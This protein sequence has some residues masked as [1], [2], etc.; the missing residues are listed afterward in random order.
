VQNQSNEKKTDRRRFHAG[1]H[2]GA[3]TSAFSIAGAIVL[4]AGLAVTVRYVNASSF[5]SKTGS[6]PQGFATNNPHACFDYGFA[7]YRSGDYE[8]AAK[9]YARAGELAP[10]YAAAF[11]GAGQSELKLGH[12]KLAQS[13]LQHAL[14]LDANMPM[15]WHDLSR[16]YQDQGKFKDSEK[17]ALQG[18]YRNNKVAGLW[19][20]L[21]T[22]LE[23][24]NKSHDAETAFVTAE[25]LSPGIRERN[26][27]AQKQ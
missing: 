3:A 5:P 14:E 25:R 11:W 13:Q 18:L 17:A 15:A 12:P 27:A 21:G 24:Q 1:M 20:D 9:W 22:S 16:A 8:N 7:R 23:A 2:V 19:L 26:R 4:A 6:V 10:R